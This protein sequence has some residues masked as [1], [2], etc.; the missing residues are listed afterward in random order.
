MTFFCLRGKGE[1]GASFC[2][3]GKRAFVFF[4]KKKEMVNHLLFEEGRKSTY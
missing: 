1:S 4:K 2:Y 3:G